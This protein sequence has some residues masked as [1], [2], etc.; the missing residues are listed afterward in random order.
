MGAVSLMYDEQEQDIGDVFW[1][2][3]ILQ[4]ED[5][6]LPFQHASKR[7]QHRQKQDWMVD[8]MGTMVYFGLLIHYRG[9]QWA[10]TK[11]PGMLPY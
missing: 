8:S 9:Q 6:R 2:A 7:F 10:R 11:L 3:S 1:A 5:P 4:G